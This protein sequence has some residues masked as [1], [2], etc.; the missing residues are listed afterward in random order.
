MAANPRAVARALPPAN[1]G[2]ATSPGGF[3]GV[4]AA[5]GTPAV[6]GLSPLVASYDQWTAG[7]PYGTALPRDPSTFLASAFGPLSPIRPV[8]ID[9]PDPE[10]GRP[11][12]RRY[13]YQVGWNMP[14]GEP[15]SEGLKLAPFEALR[16]IA[17]SYSVARACINL[18]VQEI[19]GLEWDITPTAEAQKAMR[20][21][22]GKHKD[23][24]ERRA[25]ALRFFRRPDPEKYGSFNSWLSA[26][27][28][29]VFV[30][31]ALSIYLQPTRARG[32]GLLGSDLAALCL[33]AGDSVR[34][35]LDVRG[36]TPQPPDVAYQVYDYG[37][38][39]VDL[40]TALSGEDIVSMGDALAAEYRG[41]QL[42][43]LPY[44]PRT[45]TP[46]GFTPLEQAIVPVL[47]GM[48][49]QQYQLGYYAD[50]S[51]PGMF[52]SA[53]S[54]D[55]TPQQLREM[56]DAWNAMA[57]DPAWKHKII[58][59]P[60]GS[61]IDP[62]R[63]V[64]LAD[65][66]DEIIMTQVCMAYSVMP[67]ELGISP[68][69]STT[70]S[71]GAANQMAKAS[72]QVNQRKALRPLLK[73]LKASIFDFVLQEV[74]SQPD[75]EWMWE[76]LEEGVDEESEVGLLIQEISYG[77]KSIDEARVQRGEQPWGLPMTSDPLYMT[78]TGITPIG[79]IDPSTGEAAADQPQVVPGQPAP[80]TGQATASSPP[81][82]ETEDTP[83]TAPGAG[84][85]P[86]HA[87]AQAHAAAATQ[88][89]A[90]AKAA[91]LRELDL[92]R[93]RLVKGRTLDG[94][95]TRHIP[96]TVWEHLTTDLTQGTP[97][98]QAIGKARQRIDGIAH[99]DRRDAAVNP[100]QERI[101]GRLGDLA[102]QLRSGALSMPGFLDA[103]RSVM[104]DGIADGLKAGARHA[105]AD[106]RTRARAAKAS[107]DGA[108][109]SD[110]PV[111]DAYND[112]LDAVA[113]NEADQQ[114]P[115]F[116]GLATAI[117]ATT[118]ADGDAT[119]SLSGRIALYG[120][121]A[122]HAYEQGY[123]TTILA[124]AEP[125]QY[126]ITWHTTSTKPC[127]S[128]AARDGK[129]F[130]EQ[131]LPGWPGDG[132]F[133]PAGLCYGGGHC[134]CYLSYQDMGASWSAPGNPL[135]DSPMHA[136]NAQLAQA[137]Q[138]RQQQ[139]AAARR[140]FTASLPA[141]PTPGLDTSPQQRARARDAAREE[142]AA[143][144]SRPGHRV[145]PQ[146]VPAAAVAERVPPGTA[147]AIKHDGH[148]D[149]THE[150][151]AY[152]ARQY[153]A[154]VLEWVKDAHWHGPATVPLAD[155]AAGRRP[156]G[157]RDETKVDAMVR[158]IEDGT[159]PPH[160]IVLV[161][162]PGEGPYEVADG[163]H[164]TLAFKKAG[165]ATIRAW[166]GIV[167]TDDGPWGREMNEHRIKDA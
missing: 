44:T 144:M 120:T 137:Q 161:D 145:L 130:T 51:V 93:R 32:K 167:D 129:T 61:K 132:G 99:V 28:E 86:G 115:F 20:G 128:C 39:R 50:G 38:P 59:L 78:P 152:L 5:T 10:S 69:V 104:R 139:V 45:W 33:I 3:G 102:R 53:G 97:A 6:G 55:A 159:P 66:Y 98:E 103:G 25:E 79:A 64:P 164:R 18:R 7:R 62:I 41:D 40:M 75:M 29:E 110:G 58:V 65:Q 141:R 105:M 60:N 122:R 52:I 134:R 27:L 131:S 146:D 77:L 158:A 24:A 21:S 166:I 123:G 94:W 114:D 92:M 150:V 154:S 96:T 89:R 117:L 111:G 121:A 13:P 35:L 135:A 116:M 80:N 34:P 118:G 72:E 46:Y 85:T 88:P 90:A 113:D 16:T 148:A 67:M 87:A 109:E 48:Q 81:P 91:A 2:P 73:W 70:Q 143:Q 47:A 12:P 17:D 162:P 138:A 36:G 142:L 127:T 26:L 15:G 160:P 9:Q 49:R 4:P 63:P 133:G 124:S 43:Y 163:W 71:V 153:P 30:V 22:P 119:A 76:G 1:S 165:R 126:A 37:V 108:D 56:Q 112:Y 155:I 83:T 11:E 151:Y 140:A 157:A 42:L 106:L 82:A 136:V 23:F 101:T 149:A 125:G 14:I 147:S 8:G 57:G 95:Q 100:I 74:C 31:D 107:G 84:G 19:V 156:G 68:K 54:P